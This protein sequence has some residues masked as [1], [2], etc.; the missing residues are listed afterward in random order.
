MCMSNFKAYQSV[1]KRLKASQS[2]SVSQSV[3]KR[4]KAS[5]SVSKQSSQSVS[6]HCKESHS[7]SKRHTQIHTSQRLIEI[8]TYISRGQGLQK[9]FESCFFNWLFITFR[10]PPVDFTGLHLKVDS[11]V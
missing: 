10:P 2:V 4:L 1:S 5:R 3:L 11:K 7:V 6:K 8:V 9:D